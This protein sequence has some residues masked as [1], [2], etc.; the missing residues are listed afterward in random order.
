[1][2]F[3]LAAAMVLCACAPRV[4]HRGDA[5][6]EA[7]EWER[8][9][10]EYRAEGATEK[11]AGAEA[12]VARVYVARGDGAMAK[13]ACGEAAEW[14][15]QAAALDA[16]S[17][18]ARRIRR[19]ALALEDCGNAA[20]AGKRWRD[21]QRAFEAV[22]HVRPLHPEATRGAQDARRGLG[23]ELHTQAKSLEKRGLDGAAYATDLAALQHDPL[24]PDAFPAAV[25]L[26]RELTAA[27]HLQV[28]SI[29]VQDGGAWGLADALGE[30]LAVRVL[31]EPPLGPT[32]K[33]PMSAGKLHVT[34]EAFTWW[35]EATFGIERRK[36]D[37]DA[38]ALV[39]GTADLSAEISADLV[40]NPEYEA[41]DWIASQTEE[42]YERLQAILRAEP[43][44]KKKKRAPI[45]PRA[46]EAKV[47]EDLQSQLEERRA[48]VG[49]VPATLARG[50]ARAAWI[51]P[52]CEQSRVATA[53]VKL[54]LRDDERE[55]DV[56][57]VEKTVRVSDRTHPGSALHEVAPDPLELPELAE[58]E[59]RLAEEL[60]SGV[61]ALGKARER[62]AA[63]RVREGREALS[64]SDED[65]AVDAFVQALFLV[66]P[67]RLPDDVAKTIAGRVEHDRLKVLV[68]G[69]P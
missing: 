11:I 24:Q 31:E 52:W 60:V 42:E 1:M 7:G 5:A 40:P 44:D 14:W 20:L 2:R 49:R 25:R 50:Q 37:G 27:S 39:L 46:P 67:E 22:L 28:Q 23:K 61:D 13:G 51:L 56:Y 26:R 38:L 64:I 54:E 43:P 9:L 45:P 19:H 63:R 12:E 66:G 41:R 55:P 36:M 10:A 34:I 16:S 15:R 69:P 4:V 33:K 53:R 65:A 18:G 29:R 6:A 47:V 58:I 8:A 59:A 32:R 30:L 21:A 62:R 35:D 48:A 57:V 68:T 17:P 3:A